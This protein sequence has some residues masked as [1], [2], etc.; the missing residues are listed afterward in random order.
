MD[1]SIIHLGQGGLQAAS[2]AKSATNAVTAAGAQAAGTP[3]DAR[4]AAA[5]KAAEAFETM[6]IAQLL[7][8]IPSGSDP[9]G[10][11]GGGEA[12]EMYQGMMNDEYASKIAKTGGIGV[13][14]AVYREILK[15]QE[16]GHEQ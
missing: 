16:M 7:Q 6:F 15:M 5:R 10:P 11:F 8:N 1:L 12:E 4:H 2:A 13:S 3:P 9:N 14:D